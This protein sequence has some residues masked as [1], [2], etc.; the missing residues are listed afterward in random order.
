MN[1]PKRLSFLLVTLALLCSNISITQAQDENQTYLP[2]LPIE[3]SPSQS[4]DALVAS[5]HIS[6]VEQKAALAFWTREEIAGAKPMAMASQ[7]GAAEVD[8]AA[9]AEPDVTGPPGFAAAGA[10]APGA[11]V[12][13]M[14]AYPEDWALLA[15]IDAAAADQPAEIS[16][17]DGASQIFT[18]YW[19]NRAAALHT[20]YPHR[21]VGRLSYT[22]PSGTSYCS[23][24]SISGNVMLTAAHCLYDTTNNVWFSNWVFTPAYRNG[25]APYGAFPATTCRV[26]TAWINLTGSYSINT[27]ARHDVGVCNMGT[28]S[29]GTTLNSAVGWMGRQWNYPYVRH[30]HNLGYPFRNTSDVLI[31]DAGRCL[32]ALPDQ[33][34]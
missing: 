2:L 24:T 4:T 9:L 23:A 12:A 16:A 15:E 28:N 8:A 19:A 14:Q 6:R 21:W 18:S 29:A 17:I 1:S 33:R 22:T 31:T 13:A 20:I 10:A 7:V 27:W 11:E 34:S 32:H 5:K 25:A 3:G 26:L 30:F